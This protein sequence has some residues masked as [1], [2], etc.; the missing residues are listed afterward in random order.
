M[1]RHESISTIGET[2]KLLK[3]NGKPDRINARYIRMNV[4]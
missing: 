2:E 3:L 4:R 1:K